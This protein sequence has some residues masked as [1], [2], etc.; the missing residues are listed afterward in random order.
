LYN[1]YNTSKVYNDRT[2]LEE[3]IMTRVAAS[4]LR[5]DISEILNRVAYQGE[6]VIL[7]RNGKDTAVIIPLD[8]F[9]LLETLEDQV[10]LEDAREARAEAKVK[11]TKPL[12]VLAQELR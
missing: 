1:V 11:G 8:D 5:K 3:F 2:D 9:A 12:S 4:D 6:R 10:D 7:Q